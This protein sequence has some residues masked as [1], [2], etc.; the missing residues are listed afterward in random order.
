MD[1][2]ADYLSGDDLAPPFAHVPALAA[3]DGAAGGVWPGAV[4]AIV[5]AHAVR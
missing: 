3:G 2:D 1:P 5:A 4:A